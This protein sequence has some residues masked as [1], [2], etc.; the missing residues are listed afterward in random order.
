MIIVIDTVTSELLVLTYWDEPEHSDP[1]AST[2]PGTLSTIRLVASTHVEHGV[3]DLWSADAP[4][5]EWG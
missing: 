1:Q 5:L 4:R 3:Q 2:R